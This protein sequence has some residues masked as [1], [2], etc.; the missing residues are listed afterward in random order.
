M[1]FHLRKIPEFIKAPSH[2]RTLSLLAFLLI[3]AAIPLTV[4]VAQKQQET[5]Q[6]AETGSPQCVDQTTGI[7]TCDNSPCNELNA[8]C[9]PQIK[10]NCTDRSDNHGDIY[11]CTKEIVKVPT[12][13]PKPQPPA[14]QTSTSGAGT[15]RDNPNTP[16]AGYKWTALCGTSCTS[17]SQ[18][19]KGA[20]NHEGWCYGF[21]GGARCL[22]L[23]EAGT[24]QGACRDNP[25]GSNPPSGYK[26]KALCG[27]SCT[28]NNQC[29]KNTT[30]GEVNPD[31]SAWCWGFP[32][33]GRCLQL[34]YIETSTITPPAG[35]VQVS[36][37]KN[38]SLRTS[39][40]L[41]INVSVTGNK[42]G[43]TGI[44]CIKSGKL[45]HSIGIN[46]TVCAFKNLTPNTQYSLKAIATSSSGKP[47]IQC[48]VVVDKTLQGNATLT[49]PDGG[50]FNT[51][52]C[53]FQLVKPNIG[54]PNKAWNQLSWVGLGIAYTK[55]G[56]PYY[57]S[58]GT[59]QGPRIGWNYA[60]AGVKVQG[61]GGKGTVNDLNWLSQQIFGKSW[62]EVQAQE[63]QNGCSFLGINQACNTHTRGAP[64]PQG[65][66]NNGVCYAWSDA[67]VTAPYTVK[68]KN[69]P[70]SYT[71]VMPGS[72]KPN[73]SLTPPASVSPSP[74]EGNTVFVFDLELQG[75]GP[76][77]SVKNETRKLTVWAWD[78]DNNPLGEKTGDVTY[79]SS[80]GR[81][82]GTIDMGNT[83]S[84]NK[85]IIKIKSDRYL[86]KRV[87]EVL[88]INSGATTNI[89]QTTLI[90]G[91]VEDENPD[92]RDTSWNALDIADYNVLRDCGFGEP[93]PLPMDDPNSKY[94]SKECKSHP[95]RENA[96]LNDDGII[97]STDETM[98]I[99]NFY[100]QHGD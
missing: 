8:L 61:A 22:R 45:D 48:P 10:Y 33:G 86:R 30:Q 18:C 47:E 42:T 5:R 96:D 25:T 7:G 43:Y 55:P 95:T 51:D 93:D 6:R 100:I 56:A 54:T 72:F 71:C 63:E 73:P 98:F 84:Q 82:K 64:P 12:S 78:I 4:F 17:N 65:C 62:E 39:N 40:K 69:F 89:P 23:D 13:T 1:Q 59:L 97:D 34:R 75:V 91:D 85:V 31:T 80:T 66:P 44:A 83:I 15:C 90:A 52:P 21:D 9:G 3:I 70:P 14:S 41:G 99:K 76:S 37:T 67:P 29:P 77:Q 53:F 60:M 87:S 57:T 94:N 27:Q 32:E 24:N 92:K 28:S 74:T 36:C 19:P 26:W 49:P 35:Q 11:W 50:G 81:F 58:F 46:D 2:S 16:P 79:D 38:D 88:S 68:P 20:N